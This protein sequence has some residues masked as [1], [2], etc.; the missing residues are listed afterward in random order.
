M[1]LTGDPTRHH[2]A[3]SART[4]DSA[5]RVRPPRRLAARSPKHRFFNSLLGL[6][7][8]LAK[9]RCKVALRGVEPCVLGEGIAN[10][11]AGRLD[12]VTGSLEDFP[13]IVPTR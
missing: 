3:I 12:G 7:G 8:A 10:S 1:A 11:T 2:V 5:S 13:T 6:I 9:V 4:G